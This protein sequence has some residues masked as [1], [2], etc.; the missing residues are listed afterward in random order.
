M[1]KEGH[2]RSR[3][4]ISF[5]IFTALAMGGCGKDTNTTTVVQGASNTTLLNPLSLQQFATPLPIIPVATP[6]TT[7]VPGSEFY[8]AV[9][10]QT[11]GYDFGLR[12][13]DGTEFIDPA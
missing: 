11:S 13:K 5:L 10:E 3:T 9:A 7:T 4:V 12:R 8:T 2:L 6:D 1:K